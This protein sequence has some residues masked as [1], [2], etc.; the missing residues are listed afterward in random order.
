MP[1]MGYW[2]VK[3]HPGV[4]G[5]QM[6]PWD[7]RGVKGHTGVKRPAS[8][9]MRSQRSGRQISGAA[10]IGSKVGSKVGS[11]IG[12]KV[13]SKVGFKVDSTLGSKVGFKLKNCSRCQM[14]LG[15]Y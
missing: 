14:P 1:P 8:R 12:S 5:H 13:G 4:L 7:Y 10:M 3:C 9:F 11:L 2:G 15:G 6:P